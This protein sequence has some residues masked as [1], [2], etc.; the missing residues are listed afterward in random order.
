M[1][2]VIIKFIFLV[3][4]LYSYNK[5]AFIEILSNATHDWLKHSVEKYIVSKKKKNYAFTKSSTCVLDYKAIA[6]N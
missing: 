4:S 3:A 5:F 1:K 6:I 2:Y